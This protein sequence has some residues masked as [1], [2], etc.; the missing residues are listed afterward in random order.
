MYGILHLV[1]SVPPVCCFVVVCVMRL[2]VLLKYFPLQLKYLQ[3]R[4]SGGH[5][6]Q[7]GVSVQRFGY[8]LRVRHQWLMWWMLRRQ[9]VFIITSENVL[10]V[11]NTTC[12]RYSQHIN[13]WWWRRRLPPKRWILT[14]YWNGWSPRM[15][16]CLQSSWNLQT[17]CN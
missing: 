4:F 15:F 7:Y 9:D 12:G 17:V 3:W 8:C 1:T 2:T 6:C 14:P 13:P 16:R 5:K 10:C 11:V